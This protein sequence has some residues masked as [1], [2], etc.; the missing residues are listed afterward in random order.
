MEYIP[1]HREKKT[2][3]GMDCHF[4]LLHNHKAVYSSDGDKMTSIFQGIHDPLTHS[5]RALFRVSDIEFGQIE[6]ILGII[7][8]K[9]FFKNSN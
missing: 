6:D 8:V 3:V 9:E 1:I 2:V 7:L 5:R 4:N